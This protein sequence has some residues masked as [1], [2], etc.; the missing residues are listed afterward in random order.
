MVVIRSPCRVSATDQPSALT[1]LSPLHLV[2]CKCGILG[3]GF[4]Y[5]EVEISQSNCV[6]RGAESDQLFVVE[7]RRILSAPEG[8][9]HDAHFG[10]AFGLRI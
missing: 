5:G 2:Q 4:E 6:L 9:F 8:T 7:Q 3:K 1:S 10:C